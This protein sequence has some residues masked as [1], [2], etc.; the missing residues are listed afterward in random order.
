[1]S[2]GFYWCVWVGTKNTVNEFKL[3]HMAAHTLFPTVSTAAYS[4]IANPLSAPILWNQVNNTGKHP[5]IMKLSAL[6]ATPFDR[7]VFLDNDVYLLRRDFV[8][9]MQLIAHMSDFAMPIDPGRQLV[10]MGC[11]AIINYNVSR[12]RG[13]LQAAQQVMHNPSLYPPNMRR[14]DQE[15]IW[16]VWTKT[17][18]ASTLRILLLPD[19][20][21]CYWNKYDRKWKTQHSSYRCYA[22]HNHGYSR[23]VLKYQDGY[24]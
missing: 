21:Y 24:V 1:M 3:S 20:Y 12:S 10:P 16:I 18:V 2:F 22:W 19:E 9:S 17:N 7:T 15:A 23:D 11:S 8:S 14:G 13:L 6:L 4:N 5:W